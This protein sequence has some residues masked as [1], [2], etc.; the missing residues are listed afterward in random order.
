[1]GG[2]GTDRKRKPTPHNVLGICPVVCLVRVF[3]VSLYILG[4]GRFLVSLADAPQPIRLVG[5]VVCL[6]RVQRNRRRLWSPRM[7]GQITC[8]PATGGRGFLE[9]SLI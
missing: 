2:G 9:R 1:M 7:I 3:A 6:V 4:G 5:R 8:F